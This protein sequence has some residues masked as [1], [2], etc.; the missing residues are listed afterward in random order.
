MLIRTADRLDM[1]F[2]QTFREVSN[3]QLPPKSNGLYQVASTGKVALTF[4]MDKVLEDKTS[5]S[6]HM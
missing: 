6:P 4:T 5:R 2:E 3:L 1:P